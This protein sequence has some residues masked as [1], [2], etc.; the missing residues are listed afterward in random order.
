LLQVDTSTGTTASAAASAEAASNDEVLRHSS[1][2]WRRLA[3]LGARYGPGFF[4]RW[5]PPAIGWVFAAAVPE[6]RRTVRENLR[7][8]LG[9]RSQPEEWL[10]VLRTF[11]T[12][13]HCLTQSLGGAPLRVETRGVEHLREVLSQGGAV[14]ATAH[15]GCWDAIAALAAVDLERPITVVMGREED[16]GAARFHDLRRRREG[17]EVVHSGED[18]TAG[19]DLVRRL[20]RGGLVAL[21]IDRAGPSR[22]GIQASLFGRKVTVPE[23]PFRLA[24]LAKVPLVVV[25]ARR[26]AHGVVEIRVGRP[27]SIPRHAIRS[28]LGHAASQAI[29]EVARF[30]R[31]YPTQ[32]FHFSEEENPSAKAP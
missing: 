23:G 32:W 13:A 14:I 7:S 29:S 28:D 11:G 3:W 8:V 30:V 21:Q 5:S 20:R 12:Y 17:V 24:A 4:V 18:I 9:V 10:D 16:S 27:I 19:L 2:F 22:R 6:A 25:L 1:L 15:V 26:R 31:A